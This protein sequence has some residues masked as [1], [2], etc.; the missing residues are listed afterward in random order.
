MIEVLS[1]GP[2]ATVQDLGRPGLADLGVSR[3]GAADRGALRLANRLVGN[4]ESAAG[5]E[6]TLGGLVAA[7]WPAPPPS[8]SPAPGASCPATAV[9]GTPRSAARPAA[10]S[11]LGAPAAGLR[12]YLAVRGGLAVAPVLGSRATD[13]LSGLG[14]AVLAAGRRLPVGP[15]APGEPGDFG[16]DAGVRGPAA[17]TCH[18]AAGRRPASGLVRPRVARP[19]VRAAV[20]G[21]PG[22]QPDRHPAGR[23]GAAAAPGRRARRRRAAVRAD[24]AR[25]GAGA[26][27][28]PA[29]R[30]RPG[31]PGHRRLSGDRGAAGRRAG[32]AGPAAARRRAAVRRGRSASG[33]GVRRDGAPV[34]SGD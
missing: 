17:G 4:D 21:A 30:A 13:T 10:C 1:P 18:A 27:G 3:S 28:R 5:I 31:R 7:A 24:P 33:L 29:D 16:G 11:P 2:L 26:A 34:T 23:A 6:I 25:S 19:A 12:S 9:A 22:Q 32:P 14:P 20:A 8:P 15:A